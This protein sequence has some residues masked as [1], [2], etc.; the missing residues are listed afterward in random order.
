MSVLL[1]QLRELDI[2]RHIG[3]IQVRNIYVSTRLEFVCL[4]VINSI[5]GIICSTVCTEFDRINIFVPPLLCSG[6]TFVLIRN[7]RCNP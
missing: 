4:T 7:F 1:C 5:G 3:L 6:R 2:S